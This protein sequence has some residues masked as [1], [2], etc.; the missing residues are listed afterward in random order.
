MGPCSTAEQAPC[1]EPALILSAC[2]FLLAISEADWENQSGSSGSFDNQKVMMWCNHRKRIQP[3]KNYLWAKL[4]TFELKIIMTKDL[5]SECSIVRQ[6]HIHG[7]NRVPRCVSRSFRTGRKARL[8]Y[9][10]TRKII[11]GHQGDF[12]IAKKY[13]ICHMFFF[14]DTGCFYTSPYHGFEQ[15]L[16]N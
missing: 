15:S 7:H 12:K 13:D 5:V 11:W 2:N 14:H 4:A 3:R 1:L 10:W 6:T 8:S 9:T 16:C